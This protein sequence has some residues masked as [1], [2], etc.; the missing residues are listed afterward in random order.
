MICKTDIEICLQ[1]SSRQKLTSTVIYNIFAILGNDNIMQILLLMHLRS[2]NTGPTME[3][4]FLIYT[5]YA[6]ISVG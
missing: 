2:R 1:F 4:D 3:N 5:F 6:Y